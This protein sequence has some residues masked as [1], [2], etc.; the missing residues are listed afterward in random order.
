[1]E[2]YSSNSSLLV[3]TV[4]DSEPAQAEGDQLHRDLKQ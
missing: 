4:G 2:S 1:M 3:R